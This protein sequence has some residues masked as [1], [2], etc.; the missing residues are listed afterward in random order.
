MIILEYEHSRF[1]GCI[2]DLVYDEGSFPRSPRIIEA[3]E[4]DRGEVCLDAC[5]PGIKC[6]NNGICNNYFLSYKCD[7]LG[8]GFDGDYCEKRKLIFIFYV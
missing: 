6:M 8:T 4:V 2:K 7:C 5:Q 3:Q 1:V